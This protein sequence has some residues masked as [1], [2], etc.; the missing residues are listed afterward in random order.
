MATFERASRIVLGHEKGFSNNRADK[1]GATNYGVTWKTY[2]AY[3][4][5]RGLPYRSVKL[6]TKAEVKDIYRG[7][8]T[9]AGCQ[10]FVDHLKQENFAILLFDAAINH[11]VGN[12]VKIL[13]R[14]INDVNSRKGDPSIKVDGGFGSMTKQAYLS[15]HLNSPETVSIQFWLRRLEFYRGLMFKGVEQALTSQWTFAKGWLRRMGKMKRYAR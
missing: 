3:R 1:G 14:A 12:Q 13:Q 15:A 10:W 8:W 9:N 11:G 7:Y 4:K 6:I 2:K 5:R